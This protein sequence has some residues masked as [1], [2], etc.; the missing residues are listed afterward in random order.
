MFCGYWLKQ[1]CGRM[2][3]PG[4][5]VGCDSLMVNFHFSIVWV[6]CSASSRTESHSKKI[7]P[8]S[9]L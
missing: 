9:P 6:R 3:C 1:R 2:G 7:T 5:G 8:P 4:F